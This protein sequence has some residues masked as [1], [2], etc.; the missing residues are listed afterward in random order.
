MHIDEAALERLIAD[1]GVPREN[2]SPEEIA[3]LEAYLAG[4]PFVDLKNRPIDFALLSLVP[5]PVARTHNVVAFSRKGDTLEVALLDLGD[6]A[7]IDFLREQGLRLLPR[8]TDR[9]SMK[10][11]LLSYQERLKAEF[12]DRIRE[13]VSKLKE[14][15]LAPELA[16]MLLTH[17]L[18]QGAS[19][20]HL[21]PRDDHSLVRYRIGSLLRDT[22]VLPARAVS[23]L[24]RTMRHLAGVGS[25]HSEG[26]F[27]I[28]TGSENVLCRFSLLPV[29]EGERITIR[30]AKGQATGFTLEGL[31]LEAEAVEELY[32]A[33]VSGP[34]LIVVAGPAK[35]GKTTALY[36]MLDVLNAPHKN[37][38][39]LEDVIEAKLPR[40]GQARIRPEA[41]FTYPHGLRTLLQ[42]DPD[43]IMVGN[44]PDPETA[45]LVTQAS[46]RHLVLASLEAD[47]PQAALKQFPTSKMIVFHT[48]A[49]PQG[50]KRVVF[51][52]SMLQSLHG[53]T[54]PG[55]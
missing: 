24:A 54:D 42:Q 49:A 38:L 41:G 33:L 28:E 35:S 29:A 50:I 15:K 10:Q 36:T 7:A 32:R 5:E 45:S 44:I 11:A 30:V 6:V 17:A 40:V 20:I 26:R 53:K 37:I 18:L 16:D 52:P 8:L 47:S 3:R 22:M 14:E 21:E 39:T 51:G 43:V 9:E 12:G 27:R 19:D 25:E 34:G 31:G 48:S 1:M 55:R 23:A 13:E 4:I 46:H 2:V